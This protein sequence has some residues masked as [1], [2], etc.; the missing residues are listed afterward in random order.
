MCYA[1]CLLINYTPG[2][3]SLMLVSELCF[4]I[5]EFYFYDKMPVSKIM[6]KTKNP[7]FFINF[8]SDMQ[9]IPGSGICCFNNN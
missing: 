8:R 5:S 2:Y 7:F 1:V 4:I 3:Y 9:N 6:F